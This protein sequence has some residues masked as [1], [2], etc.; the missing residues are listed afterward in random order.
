MKKILF[1]IMLSLLSVHTYAFDPTAKPIT[2]VIPFAPGGGVDSTFKNL[3]KYAEGKGINLRPMFKPGANS[4]IGT[5][6]IADR[7][8]DGFHLGI[9]TAGGLALYSLADPDTKNI[10]IVTG[11]QTTAQVIV[12]PAKSKITNFNQLKKEL[13]NAQDLTIAIGNPGQRVVWEQILELS[14]TN[15]QPTFVPYKGAGQIVSDIAGGHVGLTYLP[16]S[17]LKS[18]VDAG[19]LIALAVTYPVSDWP[20]VPVLTSTFNSW[21]DYEF[22]HVLYVPKGTNPDIVKYWQKFI[23]EYLENVET[24]EEFKKNYT[25]ALPQGQHVAEDRIRSI[26]PKLANVL[27]NE[28]EKLK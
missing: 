28:K 10:T 17:V 9:S 8:A 7:P 12:A 3:Q 6:E 26:K 4:I 24:K 16:T 27:N 1:G 2:V 20:N 22:G 13:K 15:T 21:K 5:Q 11:I 23:K 25:F 14:N 19:N 18:Q